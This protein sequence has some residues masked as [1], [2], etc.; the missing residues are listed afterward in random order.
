[1]R[2]LA[3]G[4][5]NVTVRAVRSP[6]IRPI[7]TTQGGTEKGSQGFR[8]LGK[9]SGYE[10]LIVKYAPPYAA[11]AGAQAPFDR[12]RQT[13]EANAL[14]LFAFDGPLVPLPRASD[15]LV[16]RLIH[17]D[18]DSHLL[19]IE[20]LGNLTPLLDYL[21]PSPPG[22]NQCQVQAIL[23]NENLWRSI[24]RR[25][26]HFFA[27]LHLES[28]LETVT[29]YFGANDLPGFKNQNMIDLVP[30]V[31]VL[32]IKRHLEKYNTPDF[33]NLSEI[34]EQDYERGISD[35][36][37]S[38][39]IR[40]LWP[41]G[42]LIDSSD[43]L[44]LMPKLGVIDWEFSGPAQALAA[45]SMHPR[46]A[47]YSAVLALIEGINDSYHARSLANGGSLWT[48]APS[49][50]SDPPHPMSPFARIFRSAIIIHG[51]EIINNAIG[52]DWGGFCA[53]PGNEN[54]NNGL[55]LSLV[56]T[57]V[58]LL[59]LAGNNT[60]EFVDSQNWKQ[61]LQSTEAK[62]IVGLFLNECQLSGL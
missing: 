20:D 18:K 19:I 27:D 52:N 35:E 25:L 33:M 16:P 11:L 14:A 26:G 55:V 9:L 10:S 43:P 38:F 28:T 8:D 4:I 36:E 42:I 41:G 62:V 50:T 45:V 54:E 47:T 46:S 23:S 49:G 56:R 29:T 15:V 37:R 21:S 34:V 59:R 1:M 40:D 17:H 3:G 39:I 61:L 48:L 7:E 51:R 32:P 22:A 24:G 6:L 44:A 60:A 58:Q 57:G 2:P 31:A 5:V 53:D 30:D 13:V 12:V